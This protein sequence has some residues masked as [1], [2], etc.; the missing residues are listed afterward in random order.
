[1]FFR[2]LG[3]SGVK[4]WPKPWGTGSSGFLAAPLHIAMSRLPTYHL[5]TN[6]THAA[7]APCCN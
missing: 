2:D 3:E 5:I 4:N 1:M 6:R 7:A